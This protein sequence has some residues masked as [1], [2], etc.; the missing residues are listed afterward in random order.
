MDDADEAPGEHEGFVA[1]L[2]AD[3]HLT[4]ISADDRGQGEVRCDIRYVA[5]VPRCRC[6]WTGPAFSTTPTGFAACRRLWRDKHL[7]PFLRARRRRHEARPI[8]WTPQV[9]HG[10][11]AAEH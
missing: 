9:I 10:A 11:L 1:G 8:P 4:S 7:E 5:Y 3:G 6:G 2:R